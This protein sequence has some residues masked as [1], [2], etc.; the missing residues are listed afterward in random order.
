MAKAAPRARRP[1]ASSG[2]VPVHALVGDDSFLQR[3]ALEA[4]L[5]ALGTEVQ[6]ADVDGPGASVA[7][8]LDE[9][10]SFAMFGGRRVVV[11]RDAD[12]FISDN[13]EVLESY[14]G[15]VAPGPG[16]NVLVLRCN[17]LAKNTRVY[18]MIDGLGGIVPCEPPPQR[19]LPRWV[20]QRASEAHA[21]KLD[22]AAAVLLADLIGTDLGSLDNELA[23]LALT[24]TPGQR[25]GPDQ[26]GGDVAFRREQQMWTL[27]DALSR[28][29]PDE[30]IRIWRQL[31]STDPAAAFKAVTWLALWLEKATGAL[32]MS[33]ARQPPFAIAKALQIWPA[34]N[35]DGLLRAAGQLGPRGLLAATDRLAE[36]DYRFK[37]GVGDAARGVEGFLASLASAGP[38]KSGR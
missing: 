2:D 22:P 4:V 25:I 8:V 36:L 7:S 11:V 15:S 10:R 37:T 35:V 17:A 38:R 28:E 19:D 14:L 1:S 27:T 21:L 20:A 32:R 33:Q 9:L 5:A 12:E 34:S 23:K 31:L 26:I 29:R 24:S 3:Q 30:A 18:K 13:R 16:G 6:R